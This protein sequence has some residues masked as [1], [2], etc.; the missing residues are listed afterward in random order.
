MYARSSFYISLS[1]GEGWG[2]V[3]IT[4]QFLTYVSNSYISIVHF[5]GRRRRVRRPPSGTVW[6]RKRSGLRP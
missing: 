5:L 2:E 6:L 1:L 4:T 3:L